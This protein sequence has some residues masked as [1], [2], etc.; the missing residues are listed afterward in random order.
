MLPAA[1]P[2]LRGVRS[3]PPS[4]LPCSRHVCGG[5]RSGMASHG[6]PAP[7]VSPVRLQAAGRDGR[8]GGSGVVVDAQGRC[9]RMQ[10]L[11]A[12]AAW[13]QRLARRGGEG[14]IWIRL[15]AMG[16]W[17]RGGGS[18]RRQGSAAPAGL[19]SGGSGWPA[20]G[21]PAGAPA[22]CSRHS[23]E[24]GRAWLCLALLVLPRP[25]SW[26]PADLPSDRPPALPCPA[27]PCPALSC[28]DM[29]RRRRMSR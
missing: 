1:L 18:R 22:V 4:P 16:R 28:R 27:L 23:G 26:N 2:S 13:L 24:P 6:A 12:A 10:R 11:E 21:A 25:P 15:P 29:P 17:G 7:A 19:A 20:G 5:E 14:A 8:A 9:G 3:P